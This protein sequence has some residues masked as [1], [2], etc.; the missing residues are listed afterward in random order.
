MYSTSGMTSSARLTGV[1]TMAMLATM[2]RNVTIIHTALAMSLH[3]SC[4]CTP[5]GS[6]N[7]R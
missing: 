1:A 3:Q 2:A 4:A 5:A 7:V 6:E